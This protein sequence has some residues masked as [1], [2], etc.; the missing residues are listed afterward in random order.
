[1]VFL[2]F[3]TAL[4]LLKLLAYHPWHSNFNAVSFYQ[5]FSK[6]SINETKRTSQKSRFL[7]IFA[8]FCFFPATMRRSLSSIF[9]SATI[10]GLAT[11]LLAI[12]GNSYH[13]RVV[14]PGV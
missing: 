14:E 6:N 8:N 11:S 13:I 9:V 3:K 1:M 4:P 10:A 7:A 12:F 2:C 5:D